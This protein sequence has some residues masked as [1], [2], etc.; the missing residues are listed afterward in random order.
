[1]MSLTFQVRNENAKLPEI[2]NWQPVTLIKDIIPI[3]KPFKTLLGWTL[4]S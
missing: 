3:K 4:T 1:M 2:G